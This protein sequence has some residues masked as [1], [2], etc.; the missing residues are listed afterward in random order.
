[1]I[2]VHI[3][4]V[5]KHPRR[6]TSPPPSSDGE[7]TEQ[8]DED[9]EMEEEEVKPVPKKKRTKKVVPVGS[10]GLKK[11][12]VVKSR[13]TTDAKGYMGMQFIYHLYKNC[14]SHFSYLV[15]EDYSEYE[16]VDEE[17]PEEPKPKA[18]KPV[19]KS[20]KAEAVEKKPTKTIT[21]SKSTSSLK[22]KKSTGGLMD[23]F[24]KK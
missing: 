19:A 17:E 16:S 9:V 23:F 11:R 13:M 15:T 7:A 14:V 12:R 8:P 22:G 2:D 21:K 10:N 20:K 18:K 3:D 5:I 6:A 24:G 1:M 4:L